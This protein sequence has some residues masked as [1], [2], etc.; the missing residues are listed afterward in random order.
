MFTLSV[1]TFQATNR[2]KTE[3]ELAKEE[4]EKLRKLEVQF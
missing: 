4:Q 1:F 3:V 2:L